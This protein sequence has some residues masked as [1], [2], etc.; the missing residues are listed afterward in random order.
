MHQIN[1]RLCEQLDALK[2]CFNSDQTDWVYANDG[3]R[4]MVYKLQR[5][6]CRKS[7]K[8]DVMIICG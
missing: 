2:A 4:R 3:K 5:E 7:E 8:C 6:R 1:G